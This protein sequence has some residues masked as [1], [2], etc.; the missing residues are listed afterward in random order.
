MR[1][2]RVFGPSS[3]ADPHVVREAM[4]EEAE[5]LGVIEMLADGGREVAGGGVAGGRFRH[6]GGAQR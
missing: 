2:Y 5:H 3:K 4:G 6:P 1:R